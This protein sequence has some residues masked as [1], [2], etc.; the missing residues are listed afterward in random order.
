MDRPTVSEKVT[1]EYQEGRS[2]FKR[3]GLEGD[4]PYAPAKGTSEGRYLWFMGFY[5]A[6][7]ERIGV[8]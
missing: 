4:C 2:C 7:Y 8:K 5:D 3:G 6:K 1:M